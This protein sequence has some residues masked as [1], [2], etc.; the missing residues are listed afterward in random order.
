MQAAVEQRKL[1]LPAQTA[2]EYP[3][4]P[5]PLALSRWFVGMTR[6]LMLVHALLFAKVLTSSTQAVAMESKV[7]VPTLVIVYGEC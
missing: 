1:F 4:L 7:C 6:T 3:W 2:Q 5:S